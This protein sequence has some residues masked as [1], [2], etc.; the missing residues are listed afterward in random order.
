MG[1]YNEL[2][3]RERLE[4]FIAERHPQ[5]HYAKRLICHRSRLAT[6]VYRKAINDG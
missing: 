6:A 3:F 5:M 2:W 1:T 4:K